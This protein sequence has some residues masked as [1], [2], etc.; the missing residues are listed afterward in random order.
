[1]DELYHYGIL[2]MKWGIRRYQNSD[3]SLTSAGKRRLAKKD[4]KWA[5]KNSEKITAKAKQ[6]VSKELSRYGNELLREPDAINRNGKLSAKTINAYN[7]KMAELMNEQV[8][9]LRSP[10]GKVIKF[11]AKR[12]EVGVLMG[13]ATEGYDMSKLKN[14]VYSSGKV[15]YKSTVLNKVEV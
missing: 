2:G 5:Q 12:S 15:A 4:E 6:K 8:S 3:G 9:N 7:R 13:L 11:V 1:M 14:G 10:S